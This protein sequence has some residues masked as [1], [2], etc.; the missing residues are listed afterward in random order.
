MPRRSYVGSA[1]PMYGKHHAEQTKKLISHRKKGV[2]LPPFTEEHKQ[3]ISKALKGREVPWTEKLVQRNFVQGYDF[4]YVLGAI[5]GD[6]SLYIGK[7]AENVVYILTLAARDRDFIEGF[8][9]H[10]QALTGRKAKVRS[11]YKCGKPFFQTS[12]ANKGLYQLLS[13]IKHGQNYQNLIAL[14]EEA[15]KGLLAGVIDSEGYVNSEEPCVV[16]TNEGIA[17]LSILQKILSEFTISSNVYVRKQKAGFKI[18]SQI[19]RLEI[20]R[21]NSLRHLRKLFHLHIHRKERKLSE[22]NNS[23]II[24]RKL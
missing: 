8:C 12:P 21:I 22:I 1:N 9:Q 19:G 15:K 14:A 6:G 18:N 7:R 10:Y 16:V 3:R 2:K 24:A 11:Y 23:R 4:G 5:L 13:P 17:L 20:R